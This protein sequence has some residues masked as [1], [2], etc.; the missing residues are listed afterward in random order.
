[1]LRLRT[2]TRVVR[3]LHGC[4]STLFLQGTWCYESANEAASVA[5]ANNRAHSITDDAEASQ[6]S[7]SIDVC[8]E[9]SDTKV[10]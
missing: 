7:R 9:V 8:C 5:A 3:L 6:W 10:F 2:K 4:Q 1:M